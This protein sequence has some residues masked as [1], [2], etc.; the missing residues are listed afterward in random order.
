MANSLK[1]NK[2]DLGKAKVFAAA[3][4]LND[5]GSDAVK[6]FWPTFVTSIIGAPA[7][8]LGLLD[9][10]G[11]VIS[12][13]IRWP[14]GYLS[15][16]FKTR[17]PLI[18][19]GYSLAALS[20][21]GYALSR[22]VGLL[23]PFKAMDRLGKLR[24]PP[25]DAL[26]AEIVPK[27]KR[28]KAFGLLTAADNFGATL[29]PLLGLLLFTI[30]S[31]RLTFAI[32]A[33][34]SFI[35]A[36]LILF[37]IKEQKLPRKQKSSKKS[38]IVPNGDFKKLLVTVSLFALGWI[39]TSFLILF[40][41]KVKGL[42]VALSSLFFFILSGF[43]VISSYNFG[44]I[45]DK[46]GRRNTLLASYLVYSLTLFGFFAFYFF[47]TSF[48]A[49]LGIL[50][51]LFALYGISFGAVST[52]HSAFAIDLV[53]KNYRAQASGLLSML[54]GFSALFASTIGGLLWDLSSPATTFGFSASMSLLSILPML[55]IKHK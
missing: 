37:L 32:A 4:L 11:E 21:I 12:Y 9:G 28:G 1:M 39:S 33:I 2:K 13:G 49:T 17:K 45:S 31:Y 7:S 5:L 53:G 50:V 8:I 52:I 24:D 55:T 27:N 25:R 16:K 40:A 19:F 48:L 43:S 10:F 36:L 22:S 34:P 44:K 42:P 20:R 14:A 41:M 18:W 30:L 38:I 29:A 26:L 54:F 3:S 6:P 15:D 35:S 23:F 47:E 51:C 46:L